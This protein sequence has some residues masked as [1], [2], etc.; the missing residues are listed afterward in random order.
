MGAPP[1]EGSGKPGVAGG[2]GVG[3][4]VPGGGREA[5]DHEADGP[6]GEGSEGARSHA[7]V[8]FDDPR[9]IRAIVM[10]L[11]HVKAI[12]TATEVLVTNPKDPLVVPFVWDLQSRV[13][14][15]QQVIVGSFM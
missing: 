11:E 2:V 14:A 8:P 5:H 13:G 1:P 7:V 3:E 9:S 4:V 6:P 15:S 12:I 10:N